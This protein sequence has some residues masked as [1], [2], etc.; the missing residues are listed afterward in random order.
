MPEPQRTRL[1]RHDVE[2]SWRAASADLTAQLRRLGRAAALTGA[3]ATTLSAAARRVE[4]LT[5]DLDRDLR[6]GVLLG[7]FD[8]GA[9][10]QDGIR[11]I[12]DH[13]VRILPLTM[14]LD[15]RSAVARYRPEELS[16]GSPGLLHGGDAA[17]LIDCMCGL[18]IEESS[19]VSRTAS[20]TL[21]YRAPTPLD[22][23]L[24]L[25]A[26]IERRE[27]RKLWVVATIE[28]SG[29]VT[30]EARGLFITPRS[31]SGPAGPDPTDQ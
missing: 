13:N 23:E 21:D 30:V 1:H 11:S 14:H 2:E 22:A 27:G 18:L 8:Q 12:G 15:G 10:A 28:A 29:I 26:T 31:V 5:A 19:T 25:R 9:I 3:G 24:T 17:W 4:E 7:D 6:R 16:E 20:L